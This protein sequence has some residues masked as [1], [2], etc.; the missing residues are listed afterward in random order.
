MGRSHYGKIEMAT[1]GWWMENFHSLCANGKNCLI[2]NGRKIMG[3]INEIL[4]S[5]RSDCAVK[6]F[7]SLFHV[8]SFINVAMEHG[9]H[10]FSVSWT[11]EIGFWWQ[12]SLVMSRAFVLTLSQLFRT[13]AFSESNI[14]RRSHILCIFRMVI[15][16]IRFRHSTW[17]S[18][19]MSA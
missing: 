13:C 10:K 18:S 15:G 17:K 16:M 4:C 3:F 6:M 9:L 2:L 8:R 7:M 5:F 14:C 19:I 11:C 1:D 12:L